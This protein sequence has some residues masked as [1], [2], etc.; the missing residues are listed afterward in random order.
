MENK[1][2]A[3]ELCELCGN[4]SEMD[5]NAIISGG[6]KSYFLQDAKI[7]FDCYGDAPSDYVLAIKIIKHRDD[8]APGY[9][10]EFIKNNEL[11][12]EKDNNVP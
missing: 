1:M 6:D 7:C 3:N 2:D 4:R 9:K 5:F 12:T 8:I 11:K 10:D